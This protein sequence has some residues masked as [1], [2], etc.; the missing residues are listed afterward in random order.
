MFKGFHCNKIKVPSCELHNGQKS[1]SDSAVIKGM[2]IALDTVA[3]KYPPTS[4]TAKAINFAKQ[5]FPQVKRQIKNINK[6]DGYPSL[7]HFDSAI[8]TNDW[9]KQLTAALI[10]DALKKYDLKNKFEEAIVFC[11]TWVSGESTIELE[12]IFETLKIQKLQEDSLKKL[13][14]ETGWPSGGKNYPMGIYN[15]K[16]SFDY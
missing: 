3:Y 13:N 10:Y 7:T 16:L 12:Q 2:L 8:K 9:M 15:F 14:W 6:I 1:G 4:D 5:Q 11:P